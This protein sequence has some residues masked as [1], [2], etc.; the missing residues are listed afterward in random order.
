[1]ASNPTITALEQKYIELLEKK[2]AS[3][4]SADGR[5]KS[6]PS[7]VSQLDITA[8]G[9]GLLTSSR[10]N[11]SS[12]SS[13]TAQNGDPKATV[14]CC[15]IEDRTTNA[16]SRPRRTQY[17]ATSRYLHRA[18]AFEKGGITR[19]VTWKKLMLQQFQRRTSQNLK[20]P[21]MR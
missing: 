17:R 9:N 20:P 4:E 8:A 21:S 12:V 3:L 6:H 2:I 19:K 15:L 14:S 13:M 1:M 18:S 7:L 11:K 10:L 5:N 16:E